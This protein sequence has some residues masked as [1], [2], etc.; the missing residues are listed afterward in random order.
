MASGGILANAPRHRMNHTL[1]TIARVVLAA[2]AYLASARLGYAFSIPNAFVTLWPPAGV[3]LAFLLM[4]E[5]R[6]WPA[7]L[8]GAIAG[9]VASD[10]MSGYLPAFA[11]FA[12]VANAGESLFAAWVVTRRMGG[13]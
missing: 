2:L 13:P 11:L 9:S 4:S 5:R 10:P 6:E 12:A 7:L 8:V 3:T 1:E